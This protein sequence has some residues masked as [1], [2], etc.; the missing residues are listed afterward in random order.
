MARKQVL[1][2]NKFSGGVNSYS[3]PRDLEENEF[4]ILDNAS[5]DEEG[6]IRVSGGLEVKNNIDISS[7]GDSLYLPGEGLFGY[8]T[9]Y[10]EPLAIYNTY[11]EANGAD[12][13]TAWGVT[14]DTGSTGGTWEFGA[15]QTN[16]SN[17]S[18]S[19]FG[20]EQGHFAIN[21]IDYSANTLENHGSL[22][23]NGLTLKP[24]HTYNIRLDC[25]NENPWY[26]LGSN[27]PP[28][29]RLYN[30][31]LGKYLTPD[32]WSPNSDAT[33]NAL[34]STDN[35]NL[36]SSASVGGGSPYWNSPGGETISRTPIAA[37]VPVASSAAH[38][39]YASFFGNTDIDDTVTDAYCLKVIAS[40]NG[41][42]HAADNFAESDAI[43]VLQNTTYLLDCIYHTN[44]TTG[45]NY[46]GIGV[47]AVNGVSS[48]N[49]IATITL[50][51]GG[52]T[53]ASSSVKALPIC[54][55]L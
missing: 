5:V 9:D 16:D 55:K 7:I 15:I 46:V 40:A 21:Y 52:V 6:V 23:F 33:H 37:A 20:I 36:V 41:G 3:D 12:S 18:P 51:A 43:T 50:P 4:Q 34:I 49:V 54:P 11:L 39:S 24:G 45:T 25:V 29:V 31:T 8:S 13:S 2:I 48:K 53:A 19:Y 35:G 1:Q 17:R 22:S 30:D 14:S 10:Y 42:P 38:K 26:F 28:R 27:I 32:S 44:G 47:N